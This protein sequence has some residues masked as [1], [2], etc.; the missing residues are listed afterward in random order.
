ARQHQVP[1][2]VDAAANL[3]PVENLW[4]YTQLGADLVIFSGGK[5]L[6]GPQCTGLILG[7]ADLIEACR[8]NGSPN[9]AIGRVAKVG[10]EE[11][12]GL[13]TAV[14]RYLD[15]DHAAD[16]ARREQWV[17]YLIEQLDVPGVVASRIFPGPHGQTYPRVQVRFDDEG[18]CSA[19]VQRLKCGDPKILVGT[20]PRD[21]RTLFINPLTLVEEEVKL[22]AARMKD[23]LINNT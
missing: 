11:I 16:L 21:N 18:R 8:L 13:L 7:K 10:K 23:L 6:G 9:S 3:P 12:M 14:E 22:I 1:V 20:Y 15:R 19:I 4:H 5:G 2:I 17:S